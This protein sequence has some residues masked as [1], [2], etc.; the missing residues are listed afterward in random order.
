MTQ[1]NAAPLSA[2]SPRAAAV[3]TGGQSPSQNLPRRRQTFQ[4]GICFLNPGGKERTAL[5]KANLPRGAMPGATGPLPAP[6][7]LQEG[8]SVQQQFPPARPGS[9]AD[10]KE[11]GSF[12]AL[13]HFLLCPR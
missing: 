9:W 5:P 4:G 10:E 11:S 1:A 6:S 12:K 3:L 2:S 7:H 8:R 13:I